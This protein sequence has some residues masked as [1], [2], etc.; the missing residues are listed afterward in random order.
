MAEIRFY[1]LL[2]K[3]LEAALPEILVKA[4]SGGRRVVVKTPDETM[5]ERLNDHLWTWNDQSFLPHGT[6]KDGFAA[7]QPIWLTD[8]DE[9]PNGAQILILTGG[10]EAADYHAYD[11]CCTMLDGH[12]EEMIAQ[13]RARWVSLKKEG[14]HD[15][16]YWQQNENGGW[17]KK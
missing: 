14:G 9:N 11:L 7:D 12:D 3:S 15:M 10:A 5:T 8:K 2:H 4:V 1:H 16:T 17:T 6:K 13:A